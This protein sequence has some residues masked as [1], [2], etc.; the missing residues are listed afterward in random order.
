VRCVYAAARRIIE[1]REQ[2]YHFVF[3]TDIESFFPSIDRERLLSRLLPRLPDDSLDD[4]I[5]AAIST[6]IA[7]AAEFP[8]L[9]ELWNPNAGVPQ[10]GVLSPILANFYLSPFDEM[11]TSKGFKLV[12]YVDDH[13]R[14]HQDQG[15]CSGGVLR[16]RGP[17]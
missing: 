9:S 6:E 2:G 16:L 14:P 5:Q 11:L 17:S 10:G 13:C 15:G 8:G 3:E 1:L 12:R 4:M 7:N